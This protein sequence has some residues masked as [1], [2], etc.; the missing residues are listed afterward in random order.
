MTTTDAY[1]AIGSGDLDGLK[2]MD[3]ALD[4]TM[5]RAAVA[6]GHQP[7]ITWIMQSLSRADEVAGHSPLRFIRRL[8]DEGLLTIKQELVTQ[9]ANQ[10]QLVLLKWLVSEGKMV[11]NSETLYD[12]VMN[13]HVHVV[14]WLVR[15]YGLDVHCDRRGETPLHEA[16]RHGQ[17]RVVQWLV[18]DGGAAVDPVSETVAAPLWWAAANGHLTTVQWLMEQGADIGR[19]DSSGRQPI[20]VAANSGHLSIVQYLAHGS[21]I[22]RVSQSGNSPLH[23]AARGG[24]LPVVMWLVQNGAVAFGALNS[25]G[26]TPFWLAVHHSR[27][28]VIHWMITNDIAKA[29][30]ESLRT[31]SAHAQF[32][33]G[34]LM[35]HINI[36]ERNVVSQLVELPPMLST[37]VYE[38]LQTV[39]WPDACERLLA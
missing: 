34:A 33:R 38:Y 11:A 5:L 9:A 23:E 35:F 14:A 16:S 29:S 30:G 18:L 4:S 2:L 28:P 13:G 25:A 32:L 26:N 17:L 39:E 19:V 20:H 7:I 37:I 3:I 27:F 1:A 6:S 24:H 8:V 22:H 36:H 10:G 12:A 31:H 15:S 21:S